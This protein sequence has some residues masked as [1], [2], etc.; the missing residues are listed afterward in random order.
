MVFISGI[1][2]IKKRLHCLIL[3][4]L[5]N[6]EL[7]SY[8]KDEQYELGKNKG[9]KPEILLEISNVWYNYF[10]TAFVFNFPLFNQPINDGCY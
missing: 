3:I 5:Q 6:S 10:F 4:K 8:K 9:V 1:K 2:R 7:V